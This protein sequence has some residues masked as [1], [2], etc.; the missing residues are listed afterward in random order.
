MERFGLEGTFKSNLAQ[1]PCNKQEHLQIEQVSQR[2]VQPDLECV[3]GWGTQHLSGQLVALFY[4]TV[5]NFLLTSSRHYL[6]SFG[7][8]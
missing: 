8:K 6:S 1:C 5:K 2:P 3:Q 7:M 4:L